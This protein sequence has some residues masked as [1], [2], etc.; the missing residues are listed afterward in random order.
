MAAHVNERTSA[1]QCRVLPP[2]FRI[3][4]VPAR[5]LRSA[6]DWFSQ[7]PVLDHL[8]RRLMLRLKAHHEGSSKL[9]AG[10]SASRHHSFGFSHAQAQRFFTKHMLACL[11]ACEHL[12]MVRVDRAG[13]IHRVDVAGQQPFQTG[14]RRHPKLFGHFLVGRGIRSINGNQTGIGRGDESLRNRASPGDAPRADNPPF[15]LPF[16]VSAFYRSHYLSESSWPAQ[17][18]RS[19]R[20]AV[21]SVPTKIISD[22]TRSLSKWPSRSA[23]CP[24]RYKSDKQNR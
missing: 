14:R 11:G 18:T 10:L 16:H 6:I 22:K 21:E 7:L 5:E 1:S 17:A 3:G 2:G 20:D 23:P 4:R 24:I 13:D 8:R 9:N 12:G 19:G 15:H